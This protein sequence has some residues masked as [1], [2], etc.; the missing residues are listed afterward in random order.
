MNDEPIEVMLIVV[1]ALEKLGIRYLVAGSFASA[2]YGEP[3]STR[4]VDILADVKTEHVH[5]LE[6][7]LESEFNVTVEAI[8][9]ALKHKSS[10]NLIHYQSLF[11]VDIF[12]PKERRFDEEELRRR[13]LRVVATD[14]ERKVYLATVEDVILAKLDWYRQGNEIS[15]L[16]W[17]DVTGMF[18]AN[19]GRLDLSY[20]RN[21]AEDLG[22]HD[23]LAK[24]ISSPQ[25]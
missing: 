9:L 4:D 17:R 21:M 18:K 6:K 8:K 12:I 13:A 22:L 20:M 2:L 11:K 23:L 7:L 3:R 1:G 5:D 24:L 19:E 16:Q 25:G 10:F 15:D 14:P